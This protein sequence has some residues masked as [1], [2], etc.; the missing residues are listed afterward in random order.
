MRH[1][2][3]IRVN[4]RPLLLI[5]EASRFPDIRRTV[6]M[7]RSHC[8]RIGI[9]DIYLAMVETDGI[10]LRPSGVSPPEWGFDAMV[11]SLLTREAGIQSTHRN[12][13]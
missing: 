2:S 10:L 9:G 1:P 12:G 13:R 4:G 3:Y 5:Y 6:D 8:G 11:E 7:W